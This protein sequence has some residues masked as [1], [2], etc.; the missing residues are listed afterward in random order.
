MFTNETAEEMI[1]EY[2]ELK[3]SFG[4]LVSALPEGLYY[5]MH[6]AEGHLCRKFKDF[7]NKYKK[8]LKKIP[9]I[10]AEISK[11]KS[12]LEKIVDENISGGLTSEGFVKIMDDYGINRR[13]CYFTHAELRDP[14]FELRSI[15]F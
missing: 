9:G 7:E 4:E 14:R 10:N 15:K 3:H 6:S 2:G 13:T 12:F 1:F 8:A 5:P 11:L